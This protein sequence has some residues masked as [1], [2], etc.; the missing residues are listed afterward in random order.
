MPCTTGT[1]SCHKLKLCLACLIK[2][3]S[4]A[5][6]PWPLTHFA[7]SPKWVGVARR[8]CHNGLPACFPSNNGAASGAAEQLVTC[9]AECLLFPCSLDWLLHAIDGLI[10]FAGCRPSLCCMI[11]NNC[12]AAYTGVC[13]CCLDQWPEPRS[14]EAV[15]AEWGW[16]R[17]NI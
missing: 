4:A 6:C 11:G 2:C 5:P 13:C 10:D 15:W 17:V 3:P 12:L 9:Q 14:C 7:T 16:P 8:I 1:V